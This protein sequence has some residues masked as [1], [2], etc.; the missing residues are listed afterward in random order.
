VFE[1]L[2]PEEIPACECGDLCDRETAAGRW[3]HSKCE[4]LVK[5]RRERT[6]RVLELREK[7]LARRLKE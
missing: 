2:K 1:Y 4:P 6:L 5:E 3:Y 7:I